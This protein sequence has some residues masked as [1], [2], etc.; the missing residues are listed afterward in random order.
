MGAEGVLMQFATRLF[1]CVCFSAAIFLATGSYSPA[2]AQSLGV[3]AGVSGN[4]DQ[5]YFGGHVMTPAIVDRI[6]FRPN[7]E[8]GFGDDITLGAFNFE[9]VYLFAEDFFPQ[10]MRP[11]R[12]YVGG[13]PALNVFSIEDD[14]DAEPGF[15]LLGGLVHEKGLFAEFKIGQIDSP[16]VKFAVGYEWRWR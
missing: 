2:S 4:P 5:F 6:H 14:S 13:G 15:N 8:V 9:F 7:I 16:D 11:W 12:L 10:A 3:R 1:S